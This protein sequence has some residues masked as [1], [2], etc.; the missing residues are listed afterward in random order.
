MKFGA[1]AQVEAGVEGLIHV[2]E[3]ADTTPRD[4]GQVVQD[5]QVVQAKIIHIDPVARR[6]GLSMRQVSPTETTTEM[7]AAEWHEEQARQDE[8]RSSAFDALAS[9]AQ[10]L[11]ED[12]AIT[13]PEAEP[14]EAP[15]T[16]ESAAEVETDQT[17]E[18][19]PAPKKRKRTPKTKAAAEPATVVEEAPS[20][21][22]EPIEAEA[23][24]VV[25]AESKSEEAPTASESQEMPEVISE[26][27]SD[28]TEPEEKDWTVNEKPVA[29]EA[30]LETGS[31]EVPEVDQRRE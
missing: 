26:E 13:T 1:F 28:E 6:L 30:S 11:E 7:T 16:P 22:D 17:P 31:Q 18:A 24:P 3:L 20:T 25:E 27:K 12:A 4:P 19:E 15:F 10:T 14:P 8:P 21:A 23:V 29:A 2:T 9:F 5:G